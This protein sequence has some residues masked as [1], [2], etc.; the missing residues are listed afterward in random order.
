MHHN[1]IFH[2]NGEWGVNLNSMPVGGLRGPNLYYNNTSGAATTDDSTDEASV[3][4][5]VGT[6]VTDDP[7]F[8]SIVDGSEDFRIEKTSPAF[9]AG[10]PGIGPDGHESFTT[11]GAYMPDEE[12]VEVTG[13][14]PKIYFGMLPKTAASDLE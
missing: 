4:D 1:N 10:V 12:D 8:A 11:I 9:Q 2:S 13:G 6:P 3:V 5:E 7:E 14:I